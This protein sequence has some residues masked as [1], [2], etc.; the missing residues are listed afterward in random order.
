M[1]EEMKKVAAAHCR[2]VFYF[3]FNNKTEKIPKKGKIG[4]VEIEN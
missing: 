1:A 3:P 4:L 2:Q